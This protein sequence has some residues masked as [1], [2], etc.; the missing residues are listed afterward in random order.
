MV[1]APKLRFSE[2]KP[3]VSGIS[4]KPAEILDKIDISIIK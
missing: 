3:I 1:N 2:D 4:N